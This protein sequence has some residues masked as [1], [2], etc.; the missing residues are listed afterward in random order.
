M[1]R[2]I[3]K[4][5][6]R[7][8]RKT[9]GEKLSEAATSTVLGVRTRVAAANQRH[10]LHRE[11]ERLWKVGNMVM[12]LEPGDFDSGLHASTAHLRVAGTVIQNTTEGVYTLT[13]VER[14]GLNKEFTWKVVTSDGEFDY[15]PPLL[16]ANVMRDGNESAFPPQAGA[17]ILTAP[18]IL[19][20]VDKVRQVQTGPDK[21][22]GIPITQ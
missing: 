6:L 22:V 7:V 9:L 10:H 2:L 8:R 14:D 4:A 16:E 20:F 12:G 5:A 13:G 19:A 21:P 3:E 18:E 11:L 1:E 15:S 17:G